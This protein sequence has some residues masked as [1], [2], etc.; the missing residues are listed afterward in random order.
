MADLFETTFGQIPSLDVDKITV[1]PPD[2]FGHIS[3]MDQGGQIGEMTPDILGGLD[4]EMG[5]EHIANIHDSVLGNFD[6]TTDAGTF[7]AMD[8]VYGGETLYRFGEPVAE[9]HPGLFGAGNWTDP[10]GNLLFESGAD[11]FG[12]TT[13]TFP[14][15]FDTSMIDAFDGL[16]S[17]TT[18]SDFADTADFISDST[19]FFSLMDFF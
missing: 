16:D 1:E 11:V 17:I 3:I 2:I 8:N 14:P 19:D 13:I 6:I 7:T 12:N 9:S 10:S 15:D 18:M 4:V 5:G